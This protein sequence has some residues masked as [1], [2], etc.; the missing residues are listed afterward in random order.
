MLLR[1]SSITT[2]ARCEAANCLSSVQLRAP[3]T[4]PGLAAALTRR[5]LQSARF[6]SLS[7][8]MGLRL[9]GHG[10]LAGRGAQAPAGVCI[11][12]CIVF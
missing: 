4:G 1:S 5:A 2:P 9:D 12:T 11:F 3:A 7:Q 10:A 6:R 8:M